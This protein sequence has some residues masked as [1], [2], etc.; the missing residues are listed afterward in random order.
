MQEDLPRANIAPSATV[1]DAT[2]YQ[3][4]CR[5]VLRSLADNSIDSIVTD[6]PYALVS[7]V[8]RFGKPGSAPAKGNEAYQRASAGFMGKSWDTGEVAFS[9]DFW[10]ECLRVLKPGGHVVAFSG[11]RTYH[12]MAVAIEDAGFEIRDQLGWLYGSGFPKSHDVAKQIDKS[13]GFWRGKA[14]AIKDNTVGQV[15]KGTEYERTEKGEPITD[16][17]REW[18][19]WGTALK[20]AWEPIALARKA[21]SGTVAAN[22][23]SH[24]TGAININGTRIPAGN[25]HEPDRW[26]ANIVHDGSDEVLSAFPNDGDPARFFYCAKASRKDRDDG[27]DGFEQ[28]LV[29][30]AL[31]RVTQLAGEEATCISGTKNTRANTHPTVKPT[32]LMRWLCRLIT[33]TGG[34]I[35][36]PFMG[37]GSTGKAAL[38]EGFKFIGCERE[39]EYMPIAHARIAA[40][41][42]PVV[43]KTRPSVVND[44]EP[45]DLFSRVA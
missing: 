37:S 13:A 26:P 27:L 43:A 28:K 40:T 38:L 29:A 36:D 35:L 4:D 23:L 7:I 45:I 21:L 31:A 17:A 42:R 30:S 18:L 25:E 22:V 41:L 34:I 15:A 44:N 39:E 8:K 5:D 33:P 32:D 12:R 11:T 16:E 6:P 19:G 3:A 2:I 14:G 10:R 24:G 1:G 9:E 20:P